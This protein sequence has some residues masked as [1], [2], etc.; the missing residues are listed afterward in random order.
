VG[1]KALA[2]GGSGNKRAKYEKEYDLEAEI[3]KMVWDPNN[4]TG[5]LSLSQAATLSPLK[6]P[7]T[8]K[9]SKR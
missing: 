8:P 1:K 3:E 6:M 4:P 7:I 2:K 5:K 9:K